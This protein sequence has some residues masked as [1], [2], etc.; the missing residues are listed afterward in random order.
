MERL[1]RLCKTKLGKVV[2]ITKREDYAPYYV[3]DRKYFE[4]HNFYDEFSKPWDKRRMP[5]E[6]QPD[7]E[8]ISVY[9]R[10]TALNK[11]S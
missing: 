5:M 6:H 7:P 10:W 4:L 8:G 11:K 3:D 9:Q 1:H 2:F